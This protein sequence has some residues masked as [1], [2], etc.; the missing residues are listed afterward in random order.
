MA[1]FAGNPQ[2]LNDGDPLIRVRLDTSEAQ[3][4]IAE[5]QAQ[6]EGAVG[7]VAAGAGVAP[8]QHLMLA[9]RRRYDPRA[10]RFTGG[11]IPVVVAATAARSLAAARRVNDGLPPIAAAIMGRARMDPDGPEVAAIRRLQSMTVAE[12]LDRAADYARHGG[13][14]G[15]AASR[16]LEARR[17]AD[18]SFLSRA[19]KAASH[20]TKGGVLATVGRT[21]AAIRG[22]L[23]GLI[24][25][26]VPYAAG[27]YLFSGSIHGL[28]DGQVRRDAER[29]AGK[30]SLEATFGQAGRGAG[31]LFDGIGQQLDSILKDGGLL[32]HEYL[33]EAGQALGVG[34]NSRDAVRVAARARQEARERE[35]RRKLTESDDFKDFVEGQRATVPTLVEAAVSAGK[36]EAPDTITE[37][38]KQH[39]EEQISQAR[40]RAV[41]EA[42][43][44]QIGR[45]K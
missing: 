16:M 15:G 18:P 30:S 25:K 24:S 4:Q 41:Q 19:S 14:T 44:A 23:T 36:F 6:A 5:L 28:A 20:F 40:E 43:G 45:Q 10:G 11:S 3:G 37:L 27:A 38:A 1:D 34:S 21:A 35:V 9:G 26:A 32:A 8:L 2:N 29:V 22:G 17:A 42:M 33:A 12:R 13:L 31:G 7:G 39:I